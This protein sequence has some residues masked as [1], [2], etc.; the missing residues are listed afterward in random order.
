MIM[1]YISEEVVKATVADMKVEVRKHLEYCGAGHLSDEVN[2][3]IRETLN[4][5]LERHNPW[6]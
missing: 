4:K 2:K 3:I 1:N 5:V 6:I